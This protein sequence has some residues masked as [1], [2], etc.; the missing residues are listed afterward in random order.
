M[1]TPPQTLSFPNI[2]VER[3][4][5][6][7]GNIPSVLRRKAVPGPSP[8]LRLSTAAFATRHRPRS[9]SESVCCYAMTAFST[10]TRLC[11]FATSASQQRVIRSLRF[12]TK[13]PSPAFEKDNFATCVAKLHKI[14]IFFSRLRNRRAAPICNNFP[15]L[16]PYASTM[17]EKRR[18]G[19]KR[20]LHEFLRQT[21]SAKSAD[22]GLVD[23]A[24]YGVIR[25]IRGR[26]SRRRLPFRN[27]PPD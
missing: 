24:A 12:A 25:K 3:T 4:G 23:I 15:A 7:R 17:R 14:S 1:R 8:S 9:R 10:L 26:H 27:S 22:G 16:T 18:K 20:R 11:N 21:L 6:F 13:M 2:V 5:C 19:H